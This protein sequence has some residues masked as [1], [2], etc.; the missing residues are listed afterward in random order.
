MVE[1]VDTMPIRLV[2]AAISAA[3]GAGSCLGT[4]MAFFRY[5][6]VLWP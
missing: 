5:I 2:E 4:M 6:S 1:S 3:S